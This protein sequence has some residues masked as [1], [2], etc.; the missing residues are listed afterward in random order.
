MVVSL[1]ALAGLIAAGVFLILVLFTIPLLVRMTKAVKEANKALQ[2]TD[3]AIKKL[4]D[5]VDGLLDQTSSLLDKTNSLMAD[6]DNKMQTLDPVVKAAA[7]LGESVSAV[8]AS[9]RKMA[10]RVSNAHIGRTGFVSSVLT[11]LLAR[12]KRR[13]GED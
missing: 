2:S 11:S 7:D 3:E 1:S 8:N 12:R 5:D 6:V 4:T 13:R 9:S 10:K